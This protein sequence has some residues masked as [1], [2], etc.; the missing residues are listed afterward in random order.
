MFQNNFVL[1]FPYCYKDMIERNIIARYFS[2]GRR[3]QLYLSVLIQGYSKVFCH[4]RRLSK[5][6]PRE[7]TFLAFLDPM[8]Q[9]RSYDASTLTRYRPRCD[10]FVAYTPRWNF[11]T[12]F[13]GVCDTWHPFWGSVCS[14]ERLLDTFRSG[15]FHES[16]EAHAFTFSGHTL[17]VTFSMQPKS[18]HL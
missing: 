16:Q 15:L 3:L 9:L 1:V 18:C 7:R 17:S 6:P 12:Q 11:L 14:F 4:K 2:H 8:I 10:V 5:I 13:Y